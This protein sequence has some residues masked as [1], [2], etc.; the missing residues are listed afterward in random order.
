[1]PKRGKN[2][3]GFPK[4]TTLKVEEVSLTYMFTYTKRWG[5]RGEVH[6]KYQGSVRVC[7]L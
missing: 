7:L 6:G 1:M 3:G 4:L 5:E 2:P